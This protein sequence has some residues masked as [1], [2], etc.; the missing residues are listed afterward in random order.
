MPVTPLDDVV[1]VERVQKTYGDEHP[2]VALA[3]IDARFRRGTMTAV[4]GPSGSGK[5]TLLH[6]AAGLDRPTS[7]RVVLGGTDLS[8]MSEKE[9]TVLRRSRIGF[10]FQAFNLVGALTVEQ[11]ILLPSRLAGARPDPAW[12]AEV[13]ERVGLAQ[14]LRHRP[15]ELSGGQQQRVAIARALVTR[16]EVIFCDEPT[17]ALDTQTAAEVLALLGSAVEQSGQTIVMVTHDPVAASYANRVMVLAD[18]SIVRDMP[19][20]GAPRI[21]EELAMLGRRRPVASREG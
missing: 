4:M 11:N 1:V 18:G 20:P 12:V 6:C 3:G 8:S 13:V 15:A 7:G 10:V 16:P 2:V 19:Q 5:S 14:R 21:A 17:G 9:L